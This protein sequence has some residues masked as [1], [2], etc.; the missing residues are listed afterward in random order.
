MQPVKL[1]QTTSLYVPLVRKSFK[2]GHYFKTTSRSRKWSVYAT[3]LRKGG[4]MRAFSW[5]IAG[6]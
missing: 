4:A 5:V 1:V 3:D 2:I 6:T